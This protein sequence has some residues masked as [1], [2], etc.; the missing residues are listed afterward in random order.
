[1]GFIREPAVSNMFY[2]GHP[3]ALKSDIARYL[4]ESRFDRIPGDIVGVISPHAG[5]MYSGPVAAYGYKAVSES[6]YDVVI[7]IAPS[8]RKYF[9]GAAIIE[10][11]GYK[12]PI[13]IVEIDEEITG[14]LLQNSPLIQNNI[15][16]H[17]QEHSLEVQIPFL[18]TVL[19]DFG[20]VPVIM[21][22]QDSAICEELSEVIHM[23]LQSTGKKALIVGST[24]LSHYYSYERAVQ[25]DSDVIKR[26]KD[27][28]I[29]GLYSDIGK[30]KCEACGAGP[31]LTTMMLSAQLGATHSEVLKYANSGDTSG[32]KSAVVGY[33]S[34]VFYK[35]MGADRYETFR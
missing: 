27:F 11:G 21:G 35:N 4:D 5:Y 8:H 30:E 9:K 1:M 17:E 22:V 6:A 19:K 26:L 23:A 12:T 20:L 18:Q 15:D 31:M 34:A 2:P 16:V 7:V 10:K 14:R 33:V 25:L 28:D 24:D 32:D 29:K 3:I 13:G